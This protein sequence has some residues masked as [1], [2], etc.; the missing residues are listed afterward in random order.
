MIP[1]VK[2]KEEQRRSELSA[3]FAICA[4][5]TLLRDL[6]AF[7]SRRSLQCLSLDWQKREDTC[8]TDAELQPG[9]RLGLGRVECEQAAGYIPSFGSQSVG[10]KDR[11]WLWKFWICSPHALSIS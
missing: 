4:E 9:Q 11:G 1:E 6:S 10:R 5:V 8:W 2:A 3:V 7:P